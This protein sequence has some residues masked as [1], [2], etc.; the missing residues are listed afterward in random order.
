M[1]HMANSESCAIAGSYQANVGR[2]ME[3]A[4]IPRSAA[5]SRAG[6]RDRDA[7]LAQILERSSPNFGV[8]DPE[9]RVPHL[10]MESELQCYKEHLE[11]YAG[12][13]H[14]LQNE[15]AGKDDLIRHAQREAERAQLSLAL[16]PPAMI[17]SPG[18]NAPLFVKRAIEDAA[19]ARGGHVPM[20]MRST[21]NP[22]GHQDPRVGRLDQLS[23]PIRSEVGHHRC[24][25]ASFNP[26]HHPETMRDMNR[27]RA[28]RT[29]PGSNYRRFASW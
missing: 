16:A 6:L 7:R 25:G 1:E 18:P 4:P 20:H 2:C 5:P 27:C 14:R 10:D 24:W 26:A 12:E 23:G 28:S 13:I 11:L 21:R 22:E 3:S 17:S 9:V 19:A 29:R 8:F 15:S